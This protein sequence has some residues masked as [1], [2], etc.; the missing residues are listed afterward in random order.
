MLMGISAAPLLGL[1]NQA[2]TSANT[3]QVMTTM[4]YV[5]QFAME[6]M[7]AVNFFDLQIS[8]SVIGDWWYA[9][10]ANAEQVDFTSFLRHFTYSC[11]VFA[12]NPDFGDLT[13][14]AARITTPAGYSRGTIG[15]NYYLIH[16]T[17]NNDL[18]PDK[19]LNLY[20]IVTPAGQGL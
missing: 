8:D 6:S 1:F 13:S 7:L 20:R 3:D 9:Q 12:I 19:S 10:N 5:G 2:L 17:V 4:A 11:R 14:A 15:S 16:V 18:L